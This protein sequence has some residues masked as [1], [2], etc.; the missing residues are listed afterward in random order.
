V[1]S[2]AR[3]K[4][5]QVKHCERC[6]HAMSWNERRWWDGDEVCMWCHDDMTFVPADEERPPN[7]DHWGYEGEAV[8]ANGTR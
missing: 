1:G 8:F 2:D 5:G 6:G 3:R 4:V 7:V